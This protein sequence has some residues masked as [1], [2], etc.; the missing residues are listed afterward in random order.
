M[1]DDDI[2][3]CY[4]PP[5]PATEREWSEWVREGGGFVR[6]RLMTLEEILAEFPGVK[7]PRS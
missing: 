5:L 4:T 1:D 3:R 7:V 2:I 6:H